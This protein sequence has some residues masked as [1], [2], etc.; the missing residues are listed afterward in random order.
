MARLAPVEIGTRFRRTGSGYSPLTA[1][2]M[3]F[4]VEQAVP[5]L[6]AAIAGTGTY[7]LQ[8]ANTVA[9][10]IPYLTL[11]MTVVS[12]IVAGAV[13]WGVQKADSRRTRADVEKLSALMLES[14][15]RLS[16]IEAKLER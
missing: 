3:A 12:V 6:V 8:A 16:R 13:A 2:R 9:N 15:Q 7:G 10:P 5:G 14:V 1:A 4:H 11:G